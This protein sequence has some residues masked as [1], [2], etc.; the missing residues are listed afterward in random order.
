MDRYRGDVYQE[1][2]DAIAG[3]YRAVAASPGG[4]LLLYEPTSAP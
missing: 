2:N 1:L 4:K 3:S